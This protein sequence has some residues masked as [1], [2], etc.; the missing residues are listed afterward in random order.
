MS[1]ILE[2]HSFDLDLV[3]EH[4]TSY[5]NVTALIADATIA[6]PATYYPAALASPAEYASAICCTSFELDD[7][8]LPPPV[9]G[10]EQ[11]QINFLDALDLDWVV[12][13]EAADPF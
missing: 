6:I 3:D 13:A 7:G 2:I 1:D 4:G 10:T 12:D 8:E 9:N 11:D 5:W